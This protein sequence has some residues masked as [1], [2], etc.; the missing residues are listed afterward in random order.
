MSGF[1][2]LLAMGGTAWYAMP[3]ATTWTAR[4]WTVFFAAFLAPFSWPWLIARG[5]RARKAVKTE[6][7]ARR[8]TAEQQ[9]RDEN[10][11]WWQREYGDAVHTGD[12]ERQQLAAEVLTAMDA[13]RPAR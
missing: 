7:T 8:H 12:A 4:F 11:A 6:V 13:N 10:I 1:L 3:A 5:Y 2:L 9:L